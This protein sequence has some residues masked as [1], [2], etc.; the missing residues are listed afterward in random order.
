MRFRPALLLIPLLF[1]AAQSQAANWSLT[2]K[3]NVPLPLPSS[4]TVLEQSCVSYMG[5]VGGSGAHRFISAEQ[6]HNNIVRFDVTFSPSGA[7]A[8]I[9]NVV[10]IPISSSLDFEGIAYTNPARN[11]VYLS[12]ENNPGVHELNIATGQ[13]IAGQD[14]A[15][16]TVFSKRQ[17]NR[18]FESLTRTL[19]G[20]TMWTGNEE[21]FTV[22]G[23]SST[24]Q[25]GSMVRLLKLNVNG[26]AVTAGPQYAY[27]T[28]P[29]HT[30]TNPSRNGLN[31]MCVM[32]DG[33]L[34]T[35]ERSGA[36]ATPAFF[37]RIFEVNF[38]GATDI[39]VGETATR[40]IG[41]SYTPVGKT[42]LWSGTI[43]PP[44]GQNFEG[45][46]L[47]PRLPDGSWVVLG[48]IDSSD[49]G[50]DNTIVAFNAVPN[51][52]ADFNADGDV[53]GGDFLAWQT[54][55]WHT[56]GRQARRGRR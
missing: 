31:D 36:D 33:T 44:G 7:I 54:R 52:T 45:L 46:G 1:G 10:N 35:L 41:K 25:L 38:A 42:Q 15:I 17:S 13:L 55:A 39:S 4:G 30:T 22:D 56:R 21:A 16:P 49:G 43:N 9:A 19:D 5:P 23:P 27:Q 14:V 29:I 2:F 40:L 53:D 12:E 28:A 3:G 50:L 32:P 26:N 20:T 18:G 8:N 24:A 51:V 34:L 48:T 37:N 47:G 11:S 6:N